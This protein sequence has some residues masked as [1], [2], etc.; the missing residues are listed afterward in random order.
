MPETP[1]PGV[2]VIVGSE[3]RRIEGLCDGRHVRTSS[4]LTRLRETVIAH[5]RRLV[6]I[7]GEGGKNGEVGHM[8]DD[9]D[10]IREAQKSL[11]WLLIKMAI[12]R[13]SSGGL[14]A[15]VSHALIKLL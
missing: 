15:G 14:G 3:L 1:Y 12:V 2:P 10:E 11:R 7:A 13:A 4:S 5:D 9:I 8:R 6:S